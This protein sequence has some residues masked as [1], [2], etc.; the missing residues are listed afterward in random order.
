MGDDTKLM[1][2]ENAIGNTL[3]QGFV[4]NLPE[5][6]GSLREAYRIHKKDGMFTQ[7]LQA[8]ITELKLSKENLG[9][10]V[11]SLNELSRDK[12]AD[13]ESKAM[14]RDMIREIHS[15]F[16]KNSRDYSSL[17]DVLDKL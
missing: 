12:D 3:A 5:I 2:A 1:K 15:E 13:P 4:Q 7:I 11:T 10:F 16:M 14:Y 6:I 9:L 17:S 8:K